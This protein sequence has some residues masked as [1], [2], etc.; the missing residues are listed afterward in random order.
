MKAKIIV[1]I[2]GLL[3]LPEFASAQFLPNPPAVGSNSASS[4]SWMA[5]AQL[6]YNWQRGSLVYG[7]ETDISGLDL[8]SRMNTTLP[9]QFNFAPPVTAN[10]SSNIDWYGTVRGRLGWAAGRNGK[11]KA[12]AIHFSFLLAESAFGDHL[13]V[14]VFLRS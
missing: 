10:T 3:A 11:R 9:R 4:S 2:A 8:D 13:F 12:T 7:F 6:G 1:A 14:A 5:G